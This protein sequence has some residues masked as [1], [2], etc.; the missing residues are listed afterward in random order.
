MYSFKDRPL[1]QAKSRKNGGKYA[2]VAIFLILLLF[3]L[4]LFLCIV[5]LP[6]TK[7]HRLPRDN[8]RD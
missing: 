6:Y 4:L 7:T 3:F 2:A 5:H 8:Q 1:K